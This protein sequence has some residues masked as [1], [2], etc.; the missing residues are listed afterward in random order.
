MAELLTGNPKQNIERKQALLNML[1][2][3]DS[4]PARIAESVGAMGNDI[5]SA[6]LGKAPSSDVAGDR[7]L[8]ARQMMELLNIEEDRGIAASDRKRRI[9]SEDTQAEYTSEDRT[10]ARLKEVQTE[11]ETIM[12]EYANKPLLDQLVDE[13]MSQ[14]KVDIK[15]LE[16]GQVGDYIRLVASMNNLKLKPLSQ[17]LGPNDSLVT[18]DPITGKSTTS[19]T[20]PAAPVKP[21][22]PGKPQ[23]LIEG[24]LEAEGLSKYSP[25]WN[26]RFRAEASDW[27][28]KTNSTTISTGIKRLTPG[29]EMLYAEF[30]KIRENSDSAYNNMMVIDLS[31]NLMK[32]GLST[33]KLEEWM[34]LPRQLLKD[35]GFDVSRLSDQEAFRAYTLRMTI[36]KVKEL[37][38]RPTDFDFRVTAQSMPGLDKD[39]LTNM[40]LIVIDKLLNQEMIKMSEKI[41]TEMFNSDYDEGSKQHKQ[42]F[43]RLK[44]EYQRQFK[45]TYKGKLDVMLDELIL[46][47]NVHKNLDTMTLNELKKVNPSLLDA[48]TKRLVGDRWEELNG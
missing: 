38:T 44:K 43:H 39:E 42:L 15:S 40:K 34:I 35:A 18:T 11:A 21:V 48:A 22:Q 4:G 24:M 3:Q 36:P 17:K 29:S 7:S 8:R 13:Y 27:L 37:G 2:Q 5:A 28:T 33:G 9:K 1:N 19:Y 6:F 25:E 16:P 10:H 31:Y 47:H 45:E 23:V 32:K 41:S 30:K 20:A 46:Y 26:A 14:N 12:G